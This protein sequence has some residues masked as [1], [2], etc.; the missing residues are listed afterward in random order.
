VLTSLRG[1][2][3]IFSTQDK[4]SLS[5]EDVA[6]SGISLIIA[7]N[8]TS[9]LGM[10]ALLGLLP[11]LPAVMGRLRQ[12]QQQVRSSVVLKRGGGVCLGYRVHDTACS[13][14]GGRSIGRGEWAQ[15]KLLLHV[16]AWQGEQQQV[17]PI[18]CC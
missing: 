18:W 13:R 5:D 15:A 11:L 3:H 8:D 6:A 10:T 4:E 1:L 16:M 2:A 9:G 12:E 17:R 7:G 14:G